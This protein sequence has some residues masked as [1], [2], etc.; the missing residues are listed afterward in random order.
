VAD[1]RLDLADGVGKPQR[2][3]LGDAQ[4]V[5]GKP[6]SGALPDAREP[7][8]LGDEPVDGCGEQSASK[9]SAERGRRGVR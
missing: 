9:A 4:D 6:L 2:L 8:E 5:K 1:G 7:S 3:L